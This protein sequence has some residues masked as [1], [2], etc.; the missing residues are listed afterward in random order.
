MCEEGSMSLQTN[1]LTGGGKRIEFIDLARGVCIILVVLQHTVGFY[2]LFLK[3]LDMPLFFVLSGL[4]F[5]EYGGYLRLLV[6]KVNKLLIPFI[7]FYLGAYLVHEARL[8]LLHIDAPN[9]YSPLDVFISYDFIN[10]PLWFLLAIFWQH[11]IFGAIVKASKKWIVQ[12]LFVA[13]VACAGWAFRR[14]G[15]YLPCMIAHG[16]S[17]LPFFYFGYLLKKTP[18]LYPNKYDRY[19][20]AISVVLVGISLAI[21]YLCGCP[22]VRFVHEPP[23]LWFVVMCGCAPFVV[24]VLLLCKIIKHIPIV[25]YLGRYSIVVLCIHSNVIARVILI[26]DKVDISFP[27]CY[28]LVTL[29]VCLCLIPLFVRFLPWFVAQK[30]LIPMPGERNFRKSTT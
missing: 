15:I 20:I 29:L 30:D 25:S 13:L 21:F 9:E 4:F 11:L 5:K 26:L 28:T 27:Y 22:K 24:A 8:L 18:L 1:E 16:I 10:G 19:N 12:A 23:H 3:M 6:K 2:P 7:F 14:E 17:H